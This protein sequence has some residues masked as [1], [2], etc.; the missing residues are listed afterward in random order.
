[1]F[2]CVVFVLCVAISLCLYVLLCLWFCWCL[3]VINLFVFVVDL[4]LFV[5]YVIWCI[6]MD[7]LCCVLYC[8]LCDCFVIYI[9]IGYLCFGAFIQRDMCC[10][11]LCFVWGIKNVCVGVCVFVAL[12]CCC[13]VL[14]LL[15]LFRVFD[16]CL[17]LLINIV[18]C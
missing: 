16:V 3:C 12:W 14:L 10:M 8:I 7:V 2:W 11:C 17:Y 9:Y 13:C 5:C 4:C 6:D 15:M 18:C 1:M